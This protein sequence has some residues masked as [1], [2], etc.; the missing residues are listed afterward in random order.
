MFQWKSYNL[1]WPCLLV[2]VRSN[3]V[4]AVTLISNPTYQ[5]VN[6]FSIIVVSSLSFSQNTGSQEF[7]IFVNNSFSAILVLNCCS[8]CLCSTVILFLIGIIIFK[9]GAYADSDVMNCK[10]TS[11]WIVM[12][13]SQYS[14]IWFD[15]TDFILNSSLV[16]CVLSLLDCIFSLFA[17]FMFCC[18]PVSSWS[19]SLRFLTHA[20]GWG[21]LC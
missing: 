11:R 2:S 17:C 9:V 19:I 8:V 18:L 7:F 10:G 4:K 20:Y 3:I 1:I 5:I 6:L 12:I 15:L 16:A 14:L 13:I 21:A